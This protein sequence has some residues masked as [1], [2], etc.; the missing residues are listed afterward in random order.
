M[1]SARTR[2]EVTLDHL[3]CRL[4]ERADIEGYPG[5]PREVPVADGRGPLSRILV[6][7]GFLGVGTPGPSW[8]AA[9]CGPASDGSSLR[10]AERSVVDLV[11]RRHVGDDC[12]QAAEVFGSRGCLLTGR[13][14]TV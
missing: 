12:A 6:P 14:A 1:V 10:Q 7:P 13:P 5:C 2:I 4:R 3:A 8:V 9:C 11:D